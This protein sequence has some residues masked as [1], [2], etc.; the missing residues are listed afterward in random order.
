MPKY[1]IKLKPLDSFFF[2]SE[3]TFGYDN[4]LNENYIVKS[5]KYPQ[6]TAL[7][8]M[9]R[10]EV[11]INKQL[12]KEFWNYTENDKKEINKLIGAESFNIESEQ[13][14]SFG[15]INRISP[16]FICKGDE[17]F[18]ELPKD[19]SNPEKNPPDKYEAYEKYGEVKTSIGTIPLL[20]GYKSK[21]GLREGLMNIKSKKIIKHD[22]VFIANENVGIKKSNQGKTEEQSYFKI[23]SYKMEKDYEFGFYLD[24]DIEMKDSFVILGAE[25]STFKLTAVKTDEAFRDIIKIEE[26]NDKL[27]LLSDTFIEGDIYEYCNFAISES[28]DFRNMVTLEIDSKKDGAAKIKKVR[29]NDNKRFKKVSRKYGFLKKGTVLY[30]SDYDKLT[31][32]ISENR[33]LTKIG[34]NIFK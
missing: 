4:K 30:P 22:E 9:L 28:I 17:K 5:N 24:I 31:K 12:L 25:R 15:V 11:L 18:I 34:Y 27:T 14:Q 33:N 32:K 19:C 8:G 3:R 16:I 23:S 20:K 2:G 10:K 1:L 7:L 6:Q 21:N 29:S 13:E 26:S